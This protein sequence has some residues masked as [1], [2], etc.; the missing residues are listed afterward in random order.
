MSTAF[1]LVSSLAWIG[2][3]VGLAVLQWADPGLAVAVGISALAGLTVV[4]GTTDPLRRTRLLGFALVGPIAA[5]IGAA[6]CV[7]SAT[8]PWGGQLVLFAVT[9][10]GFVG[11]TSAFTAA[12][13]LGRRPLSS[14]VGLAIA[15]L[16]AGI[17]V[18][19]TGRSSLPDAF[20]G[21]SLRAGEVPLYWVLSP[22]PGFESGM[23]LSV[24]VPVPMVGW[25]LVAITAMGVVVAV[26]AMF[27]QGRWA[28][29][30]LGATLLASAGTLVGL[31][32]IVG[33]LSMPASDAYADEVKRR[34]LAR[35]GERV[36]DAGGFLSTSDVTVA[37]ADLGPEI[38]GLTFIAV[39]S[40]VAL[41]AVRRDTGP[42][43][44][45]TDAALARDLSFMG[46]GFLWAAWFVMLV[47]HDDLIGSP[48][49]GSPA[50]WVFTGTT[51]LSTGLVVATWRPGGSLAIQRLREA[52]PGLVLA[53][54]FIG[55]GLAWRFATLPGLSL[56]VLR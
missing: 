47:I 5:A 22:V 6:V 3:A 19:G 35:G 34:L 53:L 33:S 23:R 42:M 46:L 14:S 49:M 44:P 51:L 17:Y 29:R 25:A 39:L 7:R 37:M 13:G 24:A 54:F 20:Y 36:V 38:V 18:A 41:L 21:F 43:E 50:E 11:A 4:R 52:T 26:A 48:G 56:G 27:G 12:A 45:E 1:P 9:W 10:A 15:G 30:L 31:P 32:S 16:S 8:S 28:S 2:L 40:V 55:A